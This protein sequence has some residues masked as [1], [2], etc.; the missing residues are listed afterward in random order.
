[1]A[2]PRFDDYGGWSI[3]RRKYK[4]AGLDILYPADK[5]CFRDSYHSKEVMLQWSVIQAGFDSDLYSS[6]YLLCRFRLLD[7]VSKK[8]FICTKF[9]DLIEEDTETGVWYEL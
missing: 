8:D 4:L 1:M 6:I 5:D 2:D 3:A 7:L 9:L